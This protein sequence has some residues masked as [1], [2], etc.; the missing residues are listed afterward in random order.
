MW[1]FSHTKCLLSA[2]TP[3]DCTRRS[4]SESAQN[5]ISCSMSITLGRFDAEE[6]FR[7]HLAP[8]AD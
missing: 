4:R 3:A 2:Y 1:T 7:G 6:L 5:D 8:R